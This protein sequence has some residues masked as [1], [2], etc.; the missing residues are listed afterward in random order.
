MI[1]R[2][3]E[4]ILKQLSEVGINDLKMFKKLQRKRMV[5][6]LNFSDE[7]VNLIED[8]KKNEEKNFFYDEELKK[9][10]ER[11]PQKQAKFFKENKIN[12]DTI[13]QKNLLTLV[14]QIGGM[15]TS[16]I[17][18]FK[19]Y[20]NQCLRIKYNVTTKDNEKSDVSIITSKYFEIFGGYLTKNQEEQISLIVESR[21]DEVGFE[22]VDLILFGKD[23]L[24]C[25]DI[26]Y[27]IKLAKLDLE[28]SL[29][30]SIIKKER[31]PISLFSIKNK[32]KYFIYEKIDIQKTLQQLSGEGFIRYTS[33]GIQYHTPTIEEY[34]N[35]NRDKFLILDSRLKGATLEMI[36]EAS[37]VTRERIRQKEKKELKQIPLEEIFETRYVKYFSHYDLSP[38]EFCQVFSL[39]MYQYRFLSLYHKKENRLL[40][41]EALMESEQLTFKEREYLETILNKN[42]LIIGNK[43]IRNRKIDLIEYLI[44][45]YAQAE[46]ARDD[47]N[48]I[49]VEYNNEHKLGFDFSSKR[50]IEGIVD[51][52][53]NVLLKYGRRMIHYQ[54]EKEDVID[55][56]NKLDFLHFVNQEITAKKLLEAYKMPLNDIDIYDEYELHNLLKKH[57]N[58]LPEC[59]KLT[60]MPFIEI[61]TIKR[62]EQVLNLL[63]E[64]SPISVDDFVLAYS[65]R[66]GVIEQTI[67]ANFLTVLEEFRKEEMYFADTPIIDTELIA[68]LESMLVNDFYFKED[69]QK[70]YEE[71]YG[72]TQI[73]DF[74]YKKIGYKNYSEFILKDSYNRADLYFEETYLNKE[75]FDV[76]DPRLYVLGSFR[77]NL[78]QKLSEFTVFQYAKNAYININKLTDYAGIQKEDIYV[79][80][81]QITDYIGDRFFTFTNIEFLVE[82]SKLNDLGFDSLFYES[83]LKGADDYRFQYLGGTTVF[84]KTKEKFYSYDLM[85]D[86]VSRYKSIDIYDLIDL[87]NQNYGIVLSKEKVINACMKRDLYYNPIMEMIYLDIDDFYEM[88]EE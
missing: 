23:I 48:Q 13:F 21:F 45:E 19:E 2:Q 22:C 57:S 32:I 59:V 54:V 62:D 83:I 58:S 72:S 33:E 10:F 88:M 47:F 6:K 63:I 77:K 17:E 81:Q 70:M 11:K 43:K 82:K 49:V 71:K 3:E 66:Y 35:C 24:G 61:G 5:E 51:R 74:I 38:E 55:T 4:N 29:V 39:S 78:D 30:L 85:E 40:S 34:I 28:R 8:M 50:A 44:E 56:I 64:L 14:E 26:D 65:D 1:T 41:K 75:I 31:K 42:F 12:Y 27:E 73:P 80:L 86:I 18:V 84:K 87:L 79:L 69:I 53:S 46:I 16:K 37:S 15:T 68:N 36:G 7:Q 52:A 25:L 20:K 9:L 60:R 76:E 67:K